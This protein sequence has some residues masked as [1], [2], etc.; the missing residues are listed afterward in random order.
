MK[1]KRKRKTFKGKPVQKIWLRVWHRE[2]DS[3]LHV[4]SRRVDDAPDKYCQF[5]DYIEIYKSGTDTLTA[6][7]NRIYAS[8]WY[9]ETLAERLRKAIRR[10]LLKYRHITPTDVDIDDFGE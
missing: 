5:S 7:T 8:D 10:W 4:T 2:G 6:L 1:T 3:T 9:P